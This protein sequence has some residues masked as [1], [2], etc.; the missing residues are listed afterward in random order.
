[1]QNTSDPF[2]TEALRL[3]RLYAEY[4][5]GEYYSPWDLSGPRCAKARAQ[6][7]SA[8]QGQRVPQAKSGV[9]AL[10]SALYQALDVT[11]RSLGDENRAF[12][13][14]LAVGG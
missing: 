2:L 3:Y 4:A 10:R 14:I 12:L 13:A 1:M 6:I 11:G 8:L 7:M 5:P 9:N